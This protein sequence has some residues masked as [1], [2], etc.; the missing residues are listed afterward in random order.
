MVENEEQTVRI[1]RG[2]RAVFDELLHAHR[3]RV[4]NTAGDAILAEFP[5]AIR[6]TEA[7]IAIQ[8]KMEEL[9]AKLPA[10]ER[11]RFRIGINELDT[12]DFSLAPWGHF[13]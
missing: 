9:D 11:L 1:F 3:G 2:H 6:A 7:A 13:A 4:F 5:S 10:N 8:R 12:S